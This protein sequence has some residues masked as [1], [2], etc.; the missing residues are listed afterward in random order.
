M[1]SERPNKPRQE[2]KLSWGE[3]VV[4][5]VFVTVSVLSM[6]GFAVA[7]VDMH[8]KD[9]MI[10]RDEALWQLPLTLIGC[11]CSVIMLIA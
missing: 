5:V 2:S 1:G 11:A 10:A 9:N 8:F 7:A 6:I 4:P 3:R